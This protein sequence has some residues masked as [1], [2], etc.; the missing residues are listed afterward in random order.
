MV[1]V[2]AEGGGCCPTRS[3]PGL[4]LG[5]RSRRLRAG[6]QSHPSS[7]RLCGELAVVLKKT[8]LV[9]DSRAAP[10]APGRLRAGDARERARPGPPASMA[11]KPPRAASA[12]SH[13]HAT[14]SRSRT[15]TG[16]LQKSSKTIYF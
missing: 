13:A 7:A 16:L 9:T 14:Y 2:S 12:R 3:P 6:S 8:T 10:R 1:L 11:S 4:A 5:S 15:D